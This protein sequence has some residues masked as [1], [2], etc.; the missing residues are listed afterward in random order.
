MQCIGHQALLKGFNMWQHKQKPSLRAARPRV[1]VRLCAP[2]FSEAR[3]P[4][5]DLEADIV[6]HSGLTGFLSVHEL[7]LQESAETLAWYLG[8]FFQIFPFLLGEVCVTHFN[9]LKVKVQG[10]SIFF[11]IS[12]K[13]GAQKTLMTRVIPAFLALLGKKKEVKI[14]LLHCLLRILGA[15]TGVKASCAFYLYFKTYLYILM[16]FCIFIHF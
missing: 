13:S 5:P 7:H 6:F 1:G 15:W 4:T 9:G 2:F 11:G 3:C 8:N 12:S 16:Y 14:Q 10:H